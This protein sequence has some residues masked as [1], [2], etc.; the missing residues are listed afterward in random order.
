MDD[1]YDM[2]TYAEIDYGQ[3][4]S[5]SATPEAPLPPTAGTPHPQL[6]PLYY[7]TARELRE[8]R[9]GSRAVR[10]ESSRRKMKS[11]SKRRRADQPPNYVPPDPRG[12]SSNSFR[13]RPPNAFKKSQ[14]VLEAHLSDDVDT[15]VEEN[16]AYHMGGALIHQESPP[17]KNFS[18][19][20][21]NNDQSPLDI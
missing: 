15:L 16:C 14:K 5:A 17:Y 11:Q 19:P 6:M 21:D 10:K 13:L 9:R 20:E 7:S 12:Q 4:S 1:D 18:S 2:S 3:I 8:S